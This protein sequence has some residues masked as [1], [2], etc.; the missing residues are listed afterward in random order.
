VGAAYPRLFT[1]SEWRAL[2]QA[3]RL[4]ERQLRIAQL[5]CAEQTLAQIAR[6]LNRSRD[7]VATHVKLL[8]RR[9]GVRSRVGVA[10]RLIERQRKLERKF[11]IAE[12]SSNREKS[13]E[14][15]N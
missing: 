6:R 4:S 7:T 9:L 13:L 5:I 11:G 15:V 3:L 12:T 2:G 1:A 14:Q 10:V 8:Y